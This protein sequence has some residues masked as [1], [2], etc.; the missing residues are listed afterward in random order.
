MSRRARTAFGLILSVLLLWWALRD[1]SFAEVFRHMAEVDLLLFSLAIGITLLQFWMR[2]ARWGV[3]LLP[4]RAGVP[5]HPRLAAT[6]IGFAANN[7][8]PARVGEF[9]RAFALGRLAGLPPATVF[10]TLVVER[11]LDGLVVVAFLFLAM[12]SP[13]FPPAAQVGGVDLRATAILAALVMVGT[14]IALFLAVVA[15]RRA[16]KLAHLLTGLLPRRLRNPVLDLLRSFSG[17]LVVLSSPRLFLAG[18]LWTLGMWGFMAV[19]FLLGFR[20][21]GIDDV[22]FAGAVFL[23]SLISLAVAIPSSPGFFGPFEAAA[24]VGLGLWNVPA[25]QAI[26]FAIGFHIAGFLPVSMIGIYFLWR[27]KLTWREVRH[28]EEVVEDELEE[29]ITPQGAVRGGEG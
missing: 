26:S 8:L 14:G 15:P 6:F 29:G 9:A 1:V 12:G 17:G 18:L 25:D 23:Q 2:A 24:R 20:A 13:A 5:F 19:S 4:V 21:F 28:S 10:G 27:T 3:L 16:A 7:L 11:L 22:P